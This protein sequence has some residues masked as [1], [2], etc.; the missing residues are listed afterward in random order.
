MHEE[1]D[2]LETRVEEIT[3][4]ASEDTPLDAPLDVSLDASLD[5][6]NQR[7]ASPPLQ[8]LRDLRLQRIDDYLNTSLSSPLAEVAMLGGLNVDLAVI[9]LRL[10]QSIEAILA[11]CKSAGEYLDAAS[12]GVTMLLKLSRQIERGTRLANDLARNYSKADPILRLPKIAQM[13]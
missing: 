4:S 3:P 8:D 2:I 6:A 1:N 9:E 11:E 10:S 13:P 12:E 5:T 7:D